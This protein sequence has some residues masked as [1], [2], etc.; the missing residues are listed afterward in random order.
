MGDPC[1]ADGE[2]CAGLEADYCAIQPGGEDGYC[3]LTGCTP[4]PDSCPGEYLCCDF[5]EGFGIDN[6]CVTESDFEVMGSMCQ[7]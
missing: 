4:S 5:P 6:F 7:G 1:T 3:T 2:E